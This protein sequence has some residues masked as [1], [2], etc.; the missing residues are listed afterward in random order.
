VQNFLNLI[1]I[2]VLSNSVGRWDE[3]VENQ[4]T[5]EW[6]SKNGR[7][8]GFRTDDLNTVLSVTGDDEAAKLISNITLPQ[9]VNV[10]FSGFPFNR[11]F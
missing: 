5:M 3:L 9:I 2:L 11:E 1:T 4:P 7:N 6:P 8:T 10:R